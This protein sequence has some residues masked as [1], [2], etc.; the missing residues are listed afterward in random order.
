[1]VNVQYCGLF[2]SAS[3]VGNFTVFSFSTS[4]GY[5][6]LYD[7]NIIAELREIDVIT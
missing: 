6:R 1:M 2:S 4:Y 3:P 5:Q 7:I